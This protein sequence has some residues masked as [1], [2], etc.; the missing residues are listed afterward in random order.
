MLPSKL[1]PQAPTGQSLS[2]EPY[3][4]VWS[5]KAAPASNKVKHRNMD[6]Y[7]TSAHVAS[8][9]DDL[10]GEQSASMTRAR[11]L[12]TAHPGLPHTTPNAVTKPPSSTSASSIAGPIAAAGYLDQV[13]SREEAA[14]ALRRQQQKAF[15]FVDRTPSKAPAMPRPAALGTGKG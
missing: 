9:G 14:R 4:D 6:P 12:E 5:P 10:W 3:D 15:P 8:E 1:Q 7:T 11:T 2:A 13:V